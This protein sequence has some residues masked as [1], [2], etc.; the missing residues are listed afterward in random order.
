MAV[1]GWQ[2]D[3]GADSISMER[4]REPTLRNVGE[5]KHRAFYLLV[6]SAAPILM[7]IHNHA[8]A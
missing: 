4:N 3:V 8:S 2:D 5:A 6:Q 1:I 7:L